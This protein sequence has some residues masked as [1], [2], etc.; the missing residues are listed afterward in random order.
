MRT[1]AGP[2]AVSALPA[3]FEA[4]E[5]CLASTLGFTLNQ[6]QALRSMEVRNGP[7]GLPK[8]SG[9]TRPAEPAATSRVTARGNRIT[10]YRANGG[11]QP[12]PTPSSA[13]PKART[14][15]RRYV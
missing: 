2:S 9:D 10:S 1:S 4:F 8:P 13:S 7:F 3:T 15:R 12:A 6:W 5:T 14:V 11:D